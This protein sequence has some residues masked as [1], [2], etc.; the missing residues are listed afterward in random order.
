MGGDSLGVVLV[1]DGNGVL[2]E[3]LSA[4]LPWVCHSC[5][6]GALLILQ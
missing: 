5:L 6:P 3:C 1:V 4:W 2:V